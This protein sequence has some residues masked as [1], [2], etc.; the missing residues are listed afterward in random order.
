MSPVPLLAHR[1]AIF[2]AGA[3]SAAGETT[4]GN[5]YA[6][7][8]IAADVRVFLGES[9]TGFISHGRTLYHSFG[10]SFG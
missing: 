4:S 7:Q 9:P 5:L 2:A 6:R 3:S 10:R 8:V 1:G